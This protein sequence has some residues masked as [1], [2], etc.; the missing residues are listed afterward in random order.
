MESI[1]KDLLQ[2]EQTIGELRADIDQLKRQLQQAQQQVQQ[3]TERERQVQGLND[4]LLA[5]KW[6]GPPPQKTV[7]QQHP[8]NMP[9]VGTQ[10]HETI[11]PPMLEL[12]RPEEK[13]HATGYCQLQ[14]M[15]WPG[16]PQVGTQPH[17][18]ITPPM[19]ELRRPEEKQHATGYRQL[20]PMNWPGSPPSKTVM[21]QQPINMPQVGTQPHETITPPMLKLQ[22]PE[23]KQHA[24]GYRQL[25]MNLQ[26]N[27]IP[28]MKWKKKSKAPEKMSRGS[29]A[30]D[31]DRA[32]FN[33]WGHTTVYSCNSDTREWRQLPDAPHTNSTLVVVH[34]TLTMVG[35]QISGRTTDSLLSLTGEG[36]GKK[37]LPS[38][39]AMPTKRY[40]TGAVCSGHSL[41]VAGGLGE[42]KTN[43]L[44]TVEVLD[45][46]TR[47]WSIASSLPHPF[48]QAAISICGERLY[49]MGGDWT[50]SVL[51]CS[52]PELLQSCQTQPLAGK[53]QTAPAK[54][55]T[56]WRY[57]ANAPHA[58]SSCATLC[59]R[60]VAVGG[61]E[62][63]AINVYNETT[64]SW[65]AMG[66]MPTARGEALVAVLD[67]KMMV[68]GG[69]VVVKGKAMS[70]II[71]THVV[72]ILC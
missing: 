49:M 12:R 26:Q 1:E 20:Q 45:T 13:Q 36:R 14:P 6:P 16:S 41:I 19:L 44:A 7:M 21:Q 29:T 38:L 10:P 30:T 47:Q 27:T 57:V 15:N 42:D 46:D 64:D 68:V 55:S 60:L 63:S 9:Q 18:T 25:P 53:R 56:I 24:T 58:L 43:R 8:I 48:F 65:E 22:Q 5:M 61:Y 71:A 35:G 34:Y 70:T 66:D 39:P 62:T 31:A 69:K 59:G 72:E 3:A 2:R 40:L 67:G 17:K 37:W 23:E 4:Q 51:S 52:V 11:T 54:K 28:Y 33:G 32:Y 50:S